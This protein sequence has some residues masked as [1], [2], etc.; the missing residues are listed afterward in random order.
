[1]DTSNLNELKTILI[2]LNE[3]TRYEEKLYIDDNTTHKIN[4]ILKTCVYKG[5]GTICNI[6]PLLIYNFSNNLFNVQV[7][8]SISQDY[9]NNWLKYNSNNLINIK[10]IDLLKIKI[11]I[12]NMD[13][14]L[15]LIELWNIKYIN[16]YSN[17]YIYVQNRLNNL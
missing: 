6:D 11:P 5:L 12:P 17:D 14:Q 15:K 10:G 2:K 1:M 16:P 7:I 4:E 8:K 3:L 9:L 13:G